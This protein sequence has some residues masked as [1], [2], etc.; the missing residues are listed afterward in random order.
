MADNITGNHDGENGRND[1]YHIHG[2]GDVSRN[3]LVSEVEQNKHPK[4]SIYEINR[5][6]FVR[7]KPD[8]S[9]KNNINK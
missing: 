4:F 7:G 2:R 6:K 3:K 1:S 9:G 5:E 8:G